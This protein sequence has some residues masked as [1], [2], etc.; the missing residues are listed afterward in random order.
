MKLRGRGIK[1]GA[2]K[3]EEKE[4]KGEKRRGREGK[5]KGR[6]SLDAWCPQTQSS[7]H[8]WQLFSSHPVKQPPAH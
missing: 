4:K 7:R 5:K 2:E 6:D 8:H 3:R 1:E